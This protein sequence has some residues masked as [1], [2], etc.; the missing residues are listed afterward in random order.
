MVPAIYN[1]P[2]GYRG[3]SY[4]PIVFKFFNSSGSPI[5]IS[6]VNGNL[7]VKEGPGL[8][9]VL[10]WSTTDSSMSIS[11]NQAVL[12]IKPG[13]CMQMPPKTYSYDFQVS[14]GQITR[15]YLKGSLPIIGDITQI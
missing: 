10:A 6:G 2:T 1:L 7:Q 3:D 13:S 12:N 5:N 4:G 11:G 9:T 15:T 8:S 14:S